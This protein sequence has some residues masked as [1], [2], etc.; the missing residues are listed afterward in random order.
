MFAASLISYAV[1]PLK[2]ADSGEKALSWM[3]DFHV[4]HLPIVAED[5][6]LVGII[7][8]DEI[9]NFFEPELS[10]AENEPELIH[11]FAY[12]YQHL[13]DVMKLIVDTNLSV[14]PVLNRDNKYI[15]IITLEVL[16]KHLADSGAVTHPGGILVLEMS[17]RDYSLAEIARL[18]EGEKAVILSSFITSPYGQDHLELTLKLNKQDLKHVIATLERFQY[19]VKASFHESDALDMLQDR[20][21]LLMKLINM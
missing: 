9:L 17:P 12:D 14:I 10:L 8:E 13:Y 11:K 6:T 4:R 21:D 1:P 20:Y 2:M 19:T 5:G 16:I 7:S 3:S 15:G 18:I